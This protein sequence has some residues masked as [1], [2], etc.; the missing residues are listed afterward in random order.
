MTNK[1]NPLDAVYTEGAVTDAAELYDNWAEEYEADLRAVGYAAAGRCASALASADPMLSSPILDLGCG[2]GLSGEALQG[3]GFKEIDGY[4][5]SEGMLALA[6]KKDCY[7]ELF[8]V[9]LAQ[10]DSIQDRGYRH[11]VLAGVLHHTHAPPETLAQTLARL[12]QEG[13]IVFSLNDE[14]LRFPGYTDYISHLVESGQVS[15]VSE[16]YGPHLPGRDVGARVYV[17]RKC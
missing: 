5:F 15:V 17:L 3:V 4:D 14:T 8:R 1:Q 9:D 7:R 2:T 16:E 10:P 11:A 6:R 13:C 12:P